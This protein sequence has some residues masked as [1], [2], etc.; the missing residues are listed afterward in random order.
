MFGLG[1]GSIDIKLEKFNFAPGE[2]IKGTVVLKLKKPTQSSGLKLVF[3]GE[4]I[5][6]YRD[7]E[8]R[9]REDKS[10]VHNFE[11]PLDGEKEYTGGEYPFEISIPG[12]VLQSGSEPEGNLGAAIKTIQFLSGDS[13]RIDWYLQSSLDISGGFDV[14]KRVQINVG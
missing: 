6:T 3:A 14:K 13:T 8:G 11:L 5:R 1:A 7:S 10:F 2:T 12:T 9:K 4:K